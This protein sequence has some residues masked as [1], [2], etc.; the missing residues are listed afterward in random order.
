MCIY[1]YI[2]ILTYLHTYILTYLH[3][4]ILTYFHTYKSAYLH[5]YI[6]TYLHDVHVHTQGMDAVG[7]APPAL[8]AGPVAKRRGCPRTGEKPEMADV[9]RQESM[10]FF[11]LACWKSRCCLERPVMRH[12]L[13]ASQ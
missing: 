12:S 10:C 1:I 8:L 3:T 2:Y 5:T 4:Y 7:A 9:K 11:P 13:K 6:L